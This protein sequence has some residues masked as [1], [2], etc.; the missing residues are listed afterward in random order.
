[1]GCMMMVFMVLCG[2]GGGD[3]DGVWY[4][5][6]AERVVVGGGGAVV[7]VCYIVVGVGVCGVGV[8][9]SVDVGDVST[10]DECVVDVVDAM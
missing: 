5:V 7:G 1:M 10:G 3:V 4:V 6:V 2:V 8:V 9:C